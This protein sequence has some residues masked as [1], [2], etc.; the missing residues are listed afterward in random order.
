MIRR[1]YE[2][3]TI[4]HKATKSIQ[5]L[6]SQG[7]RGFQDKTHSLDSIIIADAADL[8]NTDF[9]CAYTEDGD[10]IQI[11]KEFDNAT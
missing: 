11:E 1:Q 2:Y 9:A 4:T 10:I 7:S 8:A 3:Y 5:L 6:L